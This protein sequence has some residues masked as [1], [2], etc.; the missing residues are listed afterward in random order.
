[1]PLVG[2]IAAG[3]CAIIKPSELSPTSAM[4]IASLVPKYLDNKAFKVVN[5]AVAET[6]KLLELKFD[7][8][9]YTGNG[10]VSLTF[11]CLRGAI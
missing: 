2:A 6:T 9:L 1:V 3:C 10:Q 4:A 5:G 7:H 8:I 11:A